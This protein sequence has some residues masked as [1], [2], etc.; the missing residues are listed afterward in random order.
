MD[1]NL[2]TNN[3]APIGI[4]GGTSRENI[5]GEEAKTLTDLITQSNKTTE[6]IKEKMQQDQEIVAK[7]E[8]EISKILELLSSVNTEEYATSE[9]PTEEIEN[10]EEPIQ[11][12]TE[13]IDLPNILSNDEESG[14]EEQENEFIEESPKIDLNADVEVP[15]IGNEQEDLDNTQINLDMPVVVDKLP[16]VEEN[17]LNENSSN[18]NII[19]MDTLLAQATP[20]T[21]SPV[22]DQP[23][24][25]PVAETPVAPVAPVT[26]PVAET[27]VGPVPVQSNIEI[28]AST[29][30]TNAMGDGKQRSVVV[31]ETSQNNMKEAQEN[32]IL[33]YQPANSTMGMSQAA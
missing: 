26:A 5:N 11:E 9:E 4:V 21:E 3:F 10:E 7:I 2:E 18:D 33:T 12:E 13:E 25:A 23:V 1:T 29:Q 14:V 19:S 32:K 8:Q 15:K 16:D 22:L 27:P 28:I 17:N 31:N 30:I 20:T 6:E 24:T